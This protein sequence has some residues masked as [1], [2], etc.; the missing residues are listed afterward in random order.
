MRLKLLKLK[1][2]AIFLSSA[3]LTLAS[4]SC[5]T[6]QEATTCAALPRVSIGGGCAHLI[7]NTTFTLSETEL[8]D[9]LD[10]QPVAR[11][12]VPKVDLPV[13]ADDQTTGTVVNLPARGPSIV[14]TAAQWETF[15]TEAETLCRKVGSGCSL[16]APNLSKVVLK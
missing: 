11:S 5:I 8:L 15:L 16:A 7:S 13:C 10:T 2:L 4:E 1:R 12:C 9:L 3:S 6:I 14:M